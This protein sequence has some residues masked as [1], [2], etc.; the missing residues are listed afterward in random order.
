MAD[1]FKIKIVHSQSH[2]VFPRIIVGVLIFLLFIILI[3]A[4][5]KAKRENRP[6]FNLKNKKFFIENYDKLKLFGTLV[7][8]VLYILFMDILGFLV[9]SILFVTLFNL[10]YAASKEVKSIIVSV[11]ISIIAS[12]TLWFIFGYVFNITLP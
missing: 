10:L 8:F 1:F 5:L 12:V 4:L 11:V 9:A 6:L 7:L 2:L 3:Q